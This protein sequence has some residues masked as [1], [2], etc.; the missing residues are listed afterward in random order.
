[1]NGLSVSSLQKFFLHKTLGLKLE[2]WIEYNICIALIIIVSP[3]SYCSCINQYKP[4]FSNYK[5]THIF[6]MCHKHSNISIMGHKHSGNDTEWNV[7]PGTIEAH[8][9]N[10]LLV[11]EATQVE[12]TVVGSQI[13]GEPL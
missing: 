4:H 5:Y 9:L 12:G 3:F 8:T 1:M 7:R 13:L 6:Q 11:D 2:G 10:P